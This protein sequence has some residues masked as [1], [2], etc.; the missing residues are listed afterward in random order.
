MSS[1]EN[2]C[3]LKN[4]YEGERIFILGNG[5]SISETPLEMFES[6]Y[7]LAFNNIGEI[8]SDT[9]WRP[10]FYYNFQGPNNRFAPDDLDIV[11][12]NVRNDTICF[13][14][15]RW[16]KI[17]EQE[18][19]VYYLTK[20]GLH[21]TPFH[22]LD[23]QDIKKSRI[24]HL[25]DF[26]SDHIPNFVYQY[27]S[28]YGGIQVATYLG[29]DRIYFVGCDLDMEYKNPHMIFKSGLDPHR[30]DKGAFSY[31]HESIDNDCLIESVSNAVAMKIINLSY[32]NN[33]LTRVLNVLFD[34]A[35]DDHFTENYLDNIVIADR[36]TNS[37]EIKK[38]HLLAKRICD[39]KG[40]NMC[41]ATIGGDLEVYERVDLNSV[42]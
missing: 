39:H 27:H 3:D 25:F 34:T 9:D 36:E 19:K 37:E 16:S 38:S 10:S 2:I 28:M 22:E 40:I 26:W 12:D 35:T 31:I 33:Y 4:R 13:L 20:W 41:N 7:T 8:Y 24:D 17:I 18:N 21:N 14:S 11:L 23:R 15:S 1:S 32:N 30:Y 5:P 6:E 42:L 29:F